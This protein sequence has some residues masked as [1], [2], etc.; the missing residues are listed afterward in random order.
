MTWYEC[1][2]EEFRLPMDSYTV[3]DRAACT[4]PK[5]QS[6]DMVRNNHLKHKVKT[7]GY[8]ECSKC[9]KRASAL[10]AR[11]KFKEKHGDV[12]PFKMEE[13]KQKIK[14]ALLKRYGVSSILKLPEIREKGIKKAASPESRQKAKATQLKN[15]GDF[16]LTV[17]RPQINSTLK[18]KKEELRKSWITNGGKFCKSCSTFKTLKEYGTIHFECTKCKVCTSLYANEYSAIRKALLNGVSSESAKSYLGCDVAYF[19]DYIESQFRDGMTWENWSKTGWHLD[20]VIP[21]KFINDDTKAILNN[22]KNFRPLWSTENWSKNDSTPKIVLLVG[23]FGSG[24]STVVN[25]LNHKYSFS[26]DLGHDIY[27]VARTPH[28]ETAIYEVPMKVS[29]TIQMFKM[30][31]DVEVVCIV[32][33]YE[34]IKERIEQRGG[35]PNERSIKNR[36]KRIESLSKKYGTFSGTANECLNYLKKLTQIA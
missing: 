29:A 33:T 7:L 21:L 11:A 18:F 15:H 23:C 6:V 4:C 5:C 30:F 13:T 22:Y 28:N 31:F 25:S 17:F 27:D 1:P 36:I 14:E 35:T 3:N 34:V 26:K 9:R 32:E 16:N 20:H 19:S 24:K 10:V 8:Y 2:T 12:N